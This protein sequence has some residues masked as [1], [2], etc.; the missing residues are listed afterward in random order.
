MHVLEKEQDPKLA[1]A[2]ESA[3]AG[4]PSRVASL[5]PGADAEAV[6]STLPPL[7]PHASLWL[8]FTHVVTLAAG[9]TEEASAGG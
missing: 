8:M 4:L 2:A 3:L 7:R 9:V 5:S 1:A 6:L